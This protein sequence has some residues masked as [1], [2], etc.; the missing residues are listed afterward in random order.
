LGSPREPQLRP[1]A[2]RIS[3]RCYGGTIYG[4]GW[5]RREK[6]PQGEPAGDAAE[7]SPWAFSLRANLNEANLGRFSRE[8][9]VGRQRLSG[10]ADGTL[11]LGG[12]SQG[13]RDLKGSG[14]IQ[15]RDANIYELPVMLSLLK[16]LSLK[17]PDLTAFTTSDVEFLIH[18]AHG[19]VYFPRIDLSG[20]A[21]SLA[22][23]GS[24]GFDRQLALVF[25]PQLGGNRVK[26][27]VLSNLF[28]SA[29]GQIVELYVGGTA[30]QP[31]VRQEPLPAIREALENLQAMPLLQQMQPVPS[32]LRPNSLIPRR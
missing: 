25:K 3:A 30:D 18:G 20:D 2:D 8:A 26:V 15:L 12:T 1:G 21:L 17:E 31:D 9:L 22:G 10:R 13:V 29:S 28:R 4:D 24:M 32:S 19:Q 6:P 27:P 14:S 7:P 5:V 16:V 23:R 11:V